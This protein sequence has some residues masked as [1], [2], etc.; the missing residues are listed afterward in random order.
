MDLHRNTRKWPWVESDHIRNVVIYRDRPWITY[1]VRE[2]DDASRILFWIPELV[3]S[4]HHVI[5]FLYIL[6]LALAM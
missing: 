2:N 3:A 4:K 1:M 5:R 6:T